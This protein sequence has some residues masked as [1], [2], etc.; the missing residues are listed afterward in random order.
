MLTQPYKE[1][2]VIIHSLNEETNRLEM[3]MKV[4]AKVFSK[5]LSIRGWAN[6]TPRDFRGSEIHLMC[7]P[8]FT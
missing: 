6:K 7:T 4:E 5:F 3:K 2:P 8:D 1:G